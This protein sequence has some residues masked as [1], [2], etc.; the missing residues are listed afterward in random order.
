M[1]ELA[2]FWGCTIP[3]RFPFIEK[4]TRLVLGD[5]GARLSEPGGFTCCPEASLV[6]PNGLGAFYLTAARNLAVARASAQAVITPCNGCYS[7]FR[8]AQAHL[9]THRRE[10]EIVNELLAG[11]GLQWVPDQ[12]ILHLAEWLVDSVGIATVAGHVV[13]DLAGMRL[14]VHYGCH[15]LRPQPAVRWDDPLQ[16]QKLEDLVAAL[17]AHVVDYPT[18][19]QCCGAG[20]DRSGER[21]TCLDFARRKLNDM[22]AN[23][24]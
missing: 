8:E 17:G 1:K 13:K 2:M 10:A 5:L 11:E 6:Q 4:A 15:L 19:M 24:A 7:T 20:L 21:V 18:K 22:R 23:G 14:A 16:P 9:A 3:A 12:P